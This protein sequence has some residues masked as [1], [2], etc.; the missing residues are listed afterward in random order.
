[1]RS[2]T[3]TDE[4]IAY[5]AALPAV[6][7]ATPTRIHYA[8]WFRKECMKQYHAGERPSHI[9]RQAGLPPELVGYKRIE[10]CFARWRREERRKAE[11]K[12][13]Q[14]QQNSQ[15]KRTKAPFGDAL[16]RDTQDLIIEQQAR[17]IATL[18]K[19]IDRLKELAGEAE[20]DQ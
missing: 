3:F 6:E 18:E 15:Q 17:Y 11:S 10:R 12:S 19:E 1:M 2:E 20:Q 8:D 9:F 5:L 7:F 4:E 13:S 16:G 14:S